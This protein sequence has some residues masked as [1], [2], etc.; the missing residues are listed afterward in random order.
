MSNHCKQYFN[1]LI[2]T[3]EGDYV[4]SIKSNKPKIVTVKSYK[5]NGACTLKAAKSKTGSATLTIELAS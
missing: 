2:L 3:T 5:A 1:K 4:K